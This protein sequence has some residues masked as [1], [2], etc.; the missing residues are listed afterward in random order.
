MLLISIFGCLAQFF[1]EANEINAKLQKEHE[2]IRSKFNCNKNT[3]LENLTELLKNLEVSL[4][5]LAFNT[6]FFHV[7]LVPFFSPCKHSV[8]TGFKS[9][10]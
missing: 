6:C 7:N 4:N 2:T 8:A 5:C 9:N 3:P 10:C 1:K